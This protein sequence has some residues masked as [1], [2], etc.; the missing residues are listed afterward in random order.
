M[1]KFKEIS[2]KKFLHTGS[3]TLTFSCTTVFREVSLPLCVPVHTLFFF[4][5]LIIGNCNGKNIYLN[6]P[7][8]WVGSSSCI[9]FKNGCYAFLRHNN[10]TVFQVSTGQ[11][12]T[13]FIMIFFY[14]VK[15]T[16]FSLQW[17]KISWRRFFQ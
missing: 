6:N 11:N 8:S 4:F 13:S 1:R 17:C 16:S 15:L 14:F 12:I 9:I 5:K 10:F 3:Y 7:Q 2:K